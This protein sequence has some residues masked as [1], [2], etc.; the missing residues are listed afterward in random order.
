[1]VDVNA[2]V[3]RVRAIRRR[4]RLESGRP[5][6]SFEPKEREVATVAL[7]PQGWVEFGAQAVRLHR[8]WDLPS[9]IGQEAAERLREAN[10]TGAALPSRELE[11]ALDAAAGQWRIAS[12]GAWMSPECRETCVGRDQ[13]R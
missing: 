13:K 7:N 6:D 11:F 8:G 10:A 5:N 3:E 2:D 1:M 9:P 12:H 4:V